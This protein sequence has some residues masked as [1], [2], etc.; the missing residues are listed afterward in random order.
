MTNTTWNLD[1]AHSGIHF[2]IR[3]MVV[4][5]VRGRFAK[6]DGTVALDG[7]DLTRAVVDVTIDAASIDTSTPARDE[8][9]RSPDFFDVARFPQLRFRSSRVERVGV[10]RYR[11]IGDLTIRDVTREIAL[12]VEHGGQ[13]KDPWGNLR[14]AFTARGSIDRKDFGLRW[15]QVLEAGGFLVGDKVEIELEIQAVK[16]TA[17]KAA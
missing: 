10:D 13:A 11:L 14:A 12:E 9:L 7:E 3:H 8:H 17:E 6:F 16:A 5:K 15:N 2:S 1:T 4:A